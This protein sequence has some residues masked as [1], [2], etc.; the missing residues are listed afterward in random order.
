MSSIIYCTTQNIDKRIQGY[1]LER[2]KKQARE[3]KHQLII[4]EQEPDEPLHINSYYRNILKGLKKAKGRNVFIAEH[5]VLYPDGYFEQQNGQ[6][7]SYCKN[8]YYLTSSGFLQRKFSYA[9]LSSLIADKKTLRECVERKMK[10]PAKK[11]YEPGIEDPEYKDEIEWREFEYPTID[12]RHKTNFTKNGQKFPGENVPLAYWGNFRDMWDSIDNFKLESDIPHGASKISIIITSRNEELLSWTISNIR[13]TTR[14]SNIEIIVV[15]DGWQ[16]PEFIKQAFG[17]DQYFFTSYDPIGVGRSRDLGILK[18]KGEYIVILDAHMDF[19]DGWIEKLIEPIKKD[20]K[21]LTCSKSVVLTG[22]NLN[23]AKHGLL[24]HLGARLLLLNLK[25]EIPF[26]PYWS[27]WSQEPYKPGDE[28]QCIL[29]ACYA[30]KR[31]RYFEICRPWEFAVGWG[32]SEQVISVINWFFGGKCLLT[33]AVS[34][35]LYRSKEDAME[36]RMTN[37]TIPGLFYN[38][39]RL[40]ALIPMDK[41]LKNKFIE[42]IMCRA[43][44]I[45]SKDRILQFFNM[46][47]DRRLEDALENTGRKF[48]DYFEAWYPGR[49]I[50]EIFP[51]KAIAQAVP[52][53]PVKVNI[54]RIEPVPTIPSESGFISSENDRRFI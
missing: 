6:P 37:L 47:P 3:G 52:V 49:S 22:D 25:N 54:R 40:F 42:G 30:F 31:E 39:M 46:R 48:K 50:D 26:D 51:K 13:R 36:R 4:I 11:W 5:D 12:I 18:A 45:K 35:H 27:D 14:N 17:S 19:A 16:K 9:P 10:M 7:L 29:G 38:R 44:A 1:C 32:S 43:D 23:M 41:E 8:V 20:R 24:V 53:K 28:I 2:L 21:A 15:F 33:D 34:G